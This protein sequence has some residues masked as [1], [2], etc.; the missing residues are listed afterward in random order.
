MKKNNKG[1]TLIEILAVIVILG[2]IMVI[3]VP[4]VS[5]LVT[6][7]KM[8]SLKISAD[9]IMRAAQLYQSSN[10]QSDDV[11][12]FTILNG[13]ETSL[14]K[15]NYQGKVDSGTVMIYGDDEIALCVTSGRY[16]AI[17]NIDDSKITVTE[18][19]CLFNEQTQA[20]EFKEYCGDYIDELNDLKAQGN[21]TSENILSGKSALINGVLTEGTMANNGSLSAILKAGESFTVPEGFT[22][23]GMISAESL[24]TLTSSANATAADITIG[25]TAYIDG[26]E[27]VG[28]KPA[29]DTVV[30]AGSS[31]T[32]AKDGV[33]VFSYT[34]AGG[35]D[36]GETHQ[37][38]SIL[39][40][41]GVPIHDVWYNSRGWTSEN[42]GLYKYRYDMK[43]GDVFSY[44]WSQNFGTAQSIQGV[45]MT[46]FY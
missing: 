39:Y 4:E 38:H 9:G 2:I 45:N 40:K 30:F 19:S 32:A 27:V 24:E 8:E 3:A 29:F 35:V 37:M 26:V 42:S 41:N 12:K 25:K 20:F 31:Y 44:T 11:T 1:F 7:S 28:T 22:S 18:G 21:A 16:T 33:L 46:A 23:G 14:N 36:T 13:E 43:A 6:K 5:R 17:K 15:L 10:I 34:I